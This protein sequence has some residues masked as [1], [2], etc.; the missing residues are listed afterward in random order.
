MR[1][2]AARLSDCLESIATTRADFGANFL[3]VCYPSVQ[4]LMCGNRLT[5]FKQFETVLT[6]ELLHAFDHCRAEIDPFNLRHHA[7]MEVRAASL[8]GDCEFKREAK[9]GNLNLT[10]QHPV[11]TG[12]QHDGTGSAMRER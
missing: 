1:G 5:S 8:S 7:C 6:H 4:T 12:G 2:A 3:A 10:K 11:R 9:L